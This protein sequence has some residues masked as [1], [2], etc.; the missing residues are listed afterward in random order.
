MIYD[1]KDYKKGE[2]KSIKADVCIIG[3]GCAGAMVGREL[4]KRGIKVLIME[5]GPYYPPEKL[6]QRED[7]LIPK[8]YRMNAMQTT[9]CYT[10]DVLEGRCV[11]GGSVVNAADCVMTHEEVFKMWQNHYGLEG[12]DWMEVKLA[13]EEVKRDINVNRIGEAELNKNNKILLETGKK[14][15]YS[16]DTFEHNREGCVGC[17]YCMIGCSYNAK[18]SA[19]ITL[20]PEAIHNEADL[21][22]SAFVKRLIFKNRRVVKAEGIF[23]DSQTSRG[24]GLFE[25]SAKAFVLCAGAIHSPNILFNSNFSF[26]KNVGK[27]LSLQPQLPV[28]ALF[29]EELNSYR[30][31]PQAVFCNQFEEVSDKEGYGGFRIESIMVGPAMGSGFLPEIGKKGLSLMVNFDKIAA[32]L[33]L[34]PDTPSG[35]LKRMNAN[36][37]MI[38]YEMKDELKKRIKRGLKEAARIFLEAGA[39]EV[40]L[41][42]EEY[43]SLRSKDELS[44]IDKMEIKKGLTKC[45][46][47]H[48]QGTLR[49]SM[50]ENGVVDSRFKVKGTENLFAC[51][52]SIFP[53]TSSSHIMMPIYAFSM[54][55]SRR[56]AEEL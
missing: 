9:A 51:D 29:D 56:I 21:Y 40:L 20:I 36:Q 43:T 15:G 16:C 41:P 31:I 42:F 13:A 11:G 7:E 4:S 17:G 5:E 35:Y 44:K 18:K 12:V 8:L 52:S 50:K 28:I 2:T 10:I 27:N 48:P 46:S 30:G 6:S 39:K 47:A 45:I 55:A 25:V 3:S 34:F 19:L 49:M 33:V 32:V 22:P 54:V 53:T 37:P 26:P 24:K 23:L 38:F 1:E 14:L